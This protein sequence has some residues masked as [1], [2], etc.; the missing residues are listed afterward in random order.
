MDEKIQHFIS[1]TGAT[2]QVAQNMLE[3]C[4]GDLDMAVSMHLDSGTEGISE[5]VVHDKPGKSGFDDA[6]L[7]SE[8]R[9]YEEMYVE[10]HHILLIF[11]CGM[12]N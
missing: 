3:A 7:D 10:K 11:T 2:I 12:P 6:G 8:T 5:R 9:T 4:A 1:L